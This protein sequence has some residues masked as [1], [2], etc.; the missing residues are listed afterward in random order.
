MANSYKRFFQQTHYT[1]QELIGQTRRVQSVYSNVSYNLVKRGIEVFIKLKPTEES[2]TYTLKISARVN[3]KTV[4][5]F[6]VNPYIGFE[7]DG[8]AVPHIYRDGSLCLFYPKNDEWKYADSWSETLIPWA[9]LWLYYYELWLLTGEWL[10]E[11]V[12]G[13]NKESENN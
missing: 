7:V 1:F 3:S 9:S 4:K 8:K 6:P 11:G 12:H 13:K 10:G 2:T 5:I